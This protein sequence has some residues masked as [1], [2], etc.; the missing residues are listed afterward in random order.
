MRWC[1]IARD[2][3]VMIYCTYSLY[4]SIL[5]YYA[6]SCD[7]PQLLLQDSLYLKCNFF[8]ITCIIIC[9]KWPRICSTCLKHFRSIPYSWVITGF[10]TR[11]TQRASL[12]QKLLP[13][14]EHLSLHP[15]CLAGV[16]VSRWSL[17]FC[18]KVVLVPAGIYLLD[19]QCI[20]FTF[21]IF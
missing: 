5:Y 4:E 10:V 14:P 11:V 19:I 15:R 18:V 12:E 2:F 17:V 1:K 7:R 8:L 3:R 6:N 21:T 9:H 20:C 16:R 13:L